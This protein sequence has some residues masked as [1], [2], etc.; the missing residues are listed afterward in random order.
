ML[1]PYASQL[2]DLDP[3]E[4]IAATPIKLR[5]LIGAIGGERG[6]LHCGAASP[7]WKDTSP[8]FGLPK[9]QNATLGPPHMDRAFARW[10]CKVRKQ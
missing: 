6:S 1:N 9:A 7:P 8:R 10:G 5:S 3:V 2:G 4:V